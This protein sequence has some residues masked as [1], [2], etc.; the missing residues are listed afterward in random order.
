V[1]E[2]NVDSCENERQF[3]VGSFVVIGEAAG[4]PIFQIKEGVGIVSVGYKLVFDFASE[5]SR[6]H[7]APHLLD[8]FCILCWQ[9]GRGAPEHQCAVTGI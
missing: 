7:R 8:P 1:G 2:T 5:L 3:V 9:Q 6:R 4:V